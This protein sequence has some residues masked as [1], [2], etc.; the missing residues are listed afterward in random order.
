[1]IIKVGSVTLGS[2]EAEIFVGGFA[3]SASGE[4]QT[5]RGPCGGLRRLKDKGNAVAS[6]TVPTKQEFESVSDAQKFICDAAKAGGYEG[7]LTFEFVNGADTKF[8][9]AV[10]RPSN[11]SH[12]GVMVTAVWNIEAGEKLT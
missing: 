6:F 3:A 1:M 9:W 10:A 5:G 11:L 8:P 7:V 2:Y 12:I 4:T